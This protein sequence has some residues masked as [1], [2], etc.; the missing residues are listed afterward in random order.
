MR[1]IRAAC[2]ARTSL[3][4]YRGEQPEWEILLDLDALAANGRRGLDMERGCD[5]PGQP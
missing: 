3:D 4:S 1:S 2:G 5:D